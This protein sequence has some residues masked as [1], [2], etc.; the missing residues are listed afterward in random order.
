[1]IAG[2]VGDERTDVTMPAN[3]STMPNGA[4]FQENIFTVKEHI[5]SGDFEVVVRKGVINELLI[6]EVKPD[7]LEEYYFGVKAF[8][9][10][11]QIVLVPVEA[12]QVEAKQIHF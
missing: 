7:F 10:D 3:G 11:C 12:F 6:I 2:Q 4:R 5:R 9:Q 8:E 1:M